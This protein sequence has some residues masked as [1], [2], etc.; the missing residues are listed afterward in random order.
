MGLCLCEALPGCAAMHGI[1]SVFWDMLRRAPV[2]WHHRLVSFQVGCC[3][4]SWLMTLPRLQGDQR[5]I[6]VQ[7][8][9]LDPWQ[10]IQ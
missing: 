4:L 2:S 6:L 1:A 3:L 8:A 10:L 5:A 7:W 9:C